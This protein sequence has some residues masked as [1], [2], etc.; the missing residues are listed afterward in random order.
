MVNNI[1]WIKKAREYAIEHPAIIDNK[2]SEIVKNSF[3]ATFRV[4]LP[5]KY[6][7]ISETEK[8]VKKEEPVT[9][10]FPIEFP[11]KAPEIYLRNNFNRNFPHINP[12]L[13]KVKPCIY[14]GDL[15]ELL[16]QPKWFDSILDQMAEWLDNASFDKLMKSSQGW[17]PMRQDELNGF[18]IDELFKIKEK[19]KIS[20][21][22]FS[23]YVW[24]KKSNNLILSKNISN[25]EDFKKDDITI[26][27]YFSADIQTVQNKY[28]VKAINCFA[29]LREFVTECC[30]S[31]FSDTVNKEYSVLKKY[32]KNVLFI[33]LSLRRPC[34]LINSSFAGDE[35]A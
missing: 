29:D 7:I 24:Y 18:H 5:G 25:K 27:I 20:S 10:V 28:I 21:Q 6:D 13:E 32:N 11:L 15:S 23:G 4:Y 26:M 3:T 12:S 8:N 1:K 19:I 22:Y 2:V 31:N 30:V 35:P 16:Q 17:E 9:F 34:K 14:D 33:S